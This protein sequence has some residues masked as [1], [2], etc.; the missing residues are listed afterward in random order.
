MIIAT[1]D[2]YMA[3]PMACSPHLAIVFS[4][5]VTRFVFVSLLPVALNKAI[6]G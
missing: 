5:S 4:S 1:T 2:P 6:E 3:Y